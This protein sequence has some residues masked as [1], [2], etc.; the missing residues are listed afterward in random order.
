MTNLTFERAVEIAV[1][2][3]MVKEHVRQFLSPGGATVDASSSEN[4]NRVRFVPK[5]TEGRYPRQVNRF[6]KQSQQVSG[7]ECWRCGGNRY[8]SSNS[9]DVS[10]V[11]KQGILRS[12]KCLQRQ[13]KGAFCQSP[14]E[15]DDHFIVYSTHTVD[16][17]KSSGI[18]VH[19]CIE[20]TT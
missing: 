10:D 15:Q 1:H 4:V 3:T 5:Q 11:A 9:K 18:R 14:D 12:Q 19:V 13:I 17:M 8:A 16:A 20:G 6:G 2:M 7:Q